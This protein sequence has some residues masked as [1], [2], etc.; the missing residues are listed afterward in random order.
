MRRRTAAAP[1]MLESTVTGFTE[2]HTLH[3]SSSNKGKF[4]KELQCSA[5]PIS[6]LQSIASTAQRGDELPKFNRGCSTSSSA[7]RLAH[8]TSV[9]LLPRAPRPN[10]S[11]SCSRCD[12]T[13]C[14][15]TKPVVRAVVSAHRAKHV[16]FDIGSAQTANRPAG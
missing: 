10:R 8:G 6:R 15:A 16:S 5:D 1:V 3:G 2:R 7:P 13:V 4:E 9:L 14:R 11:S 12:S